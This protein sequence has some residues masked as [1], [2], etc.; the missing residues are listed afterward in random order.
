M[1]RSC[2][3]FLFLLAL[4]AITGS[5]S[6]AGVPTRVAFPL[7]ASTTPTTAPATGVLSLDS[8]P[9]GAL[10]SVDGTAAGTAPVTLSSVA[11]GWHTI[12]LTLPGYSDYTTRIEVP[13]GGSV[14]Q[15]YTLTAIQTEAPTPTTTTTTT[16]P[17]V[18]CTPPCECLLPAEAQE[19][20]GTYSQC[21]DAPCG[22]ETDPSGA[23][24]AKYCFHLVPPAVTTTATTTAPVISVITTPVPATNQPLPV[25]TV[26]VT[27]PPTTQQPVSPVPTQLPVGSASLPKFTP[28]S[29]NIAGKTHTTPLE[30]GSPLYLAQ[31]G[32]SQGLV[33]HLPQTLTFLEVDEVNGDLSDYHAG[34]EMHHLPN[35]TYADTSVIDRNRTIQFVNFRVLTAEK[36]VKAMVWQVSRFPFPANA[37]RWQNEY[38]P[39][40]IAYGQVKGEYTDS[41]GYTWFRINFARV[42]NRNPSLPPYYAGTVSLEGGGLPGMG[43]PQG[44]AKIPFTQAGIVM[45]TLTLGPISVPVPSGLQ[46]FAGGELTQEELGSPSAGMKLVSEDTVTL[47]PF[48]PIESLSLNWLDQTYY[49]RVIPIHDGGIGGLPSAPV[50]STIKRPHPCPTGLSADVTLKPPSARIISYIEILWAPNQIPSH[51]VW[52]TDPCKNLSSAP[53]EHQSYSVWGMGGNTTWSNQNLYCNIFKNGPAQGRVG[54]HYYVPPPA[55]KEHHWYDFITDFFSDL[56]GF[57]ETFVDAMAV[58]F[59]AI[60]DFAAVLVA[61]VIST[62]LTLGTYDCSAHEAC[63]DI[64]KTGEDAVLAYFGVPPTIPTFDELEDAGAEYLVSLAA[65]Q[66]GAGGIYDGLPDDAKASVA[67]NLGSGAR[68]VAESMVEGQREGTKSQIQQAIGGGWTMPDPM[69][70]APHPATVMVGVRNPNT[71]PSDRALITVRDTGGFFVPEQRIIPPLHSGEGVT[72]PVTMKEDYEQYYGNGCPKQEDAVEYSNVQYPWQID[73]VHEKWWTKFAAASQDTFTVSVGEW[74]GQGEGYGGGGAF[75]DG[76]DQGADGKKLTTYLMLDP[77]TTQGYCPISSSL[78][79]PAGWQI[80]IQG[81]TVDPRKWDNGVLDQNNGWEGMFVKEQSSPLFTSLQGIQY[82]S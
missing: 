79:Y 38:V 50:T 3:C 31:F 17:T 65:D 58:T 12:I 1:S 73:C 30:L 2:L 32:P 5:V 52:F 24:Q 37:S 70:V 49:I 35:W 80:S 69:F 42:A 66:M 19:K 51:Y 25:A 43:T 34:V 55:P 47:H 44:V 74:T 48:T 45:K 28:L 6:G 21:L 61:K 81:R 41:E 23:R 4:L 78:H 64:V 72:V 82:K 8:V 18:T 63:L 71:Q 59:G 10:V 13:A 11:G 36:D 7:P 60:K 29:I 9:S 40:L 26:P 33:S 46:F 56:L 62:V 76:L 14:R 20:F 75:I 67:K 57:F 53:P 27:V 39:G 16:V 15:V 22:Y 68:D 77:G 54:Y